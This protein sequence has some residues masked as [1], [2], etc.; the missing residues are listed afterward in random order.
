L[1]AICAKI[2][3]EKHPRAFVKVVEGSEIYNFP[4][5]YFV[6]FYSNFWRNSF[7]NRAKWIRDD[8]A[9]AKTPGVPTRTSH[10]T[11][12]SPP[13]AFGSAFSW[14][15][16]CTK[17]YWSPSLPRAAPELVACRTRRCLAVCPLPLPVRARLPRPPPYH[18]EIP[19]VSSSRGKQE[20]PI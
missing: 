12:R 8:V 4:I 9:P 7:S 15:R 19:L 18:S 11:W 20:P 10:D 16:E 1:A 14:G 17:A 6:H 2:R 13:S 5:H 3:W